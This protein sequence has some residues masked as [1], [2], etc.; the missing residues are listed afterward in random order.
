MQ[1]R[2]WRQDDL[3]RMPLSPEVPHQQRSSV[4]MI[5]TPLLKG[6]EIYTFKLLYEIDNINLPQ[7]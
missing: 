7:I 6:F 1:L 5:T 4:L 2:P 3:H